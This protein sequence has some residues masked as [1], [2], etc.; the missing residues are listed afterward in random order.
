MHN[1]LAGVWLH[2]GMGIGVAAVVILCQHR[3]ENDPH[4]CE[5]GKA[6]F[7]NVAYKK[8]KRMSK[9]D[10]SISGYFHSSPASS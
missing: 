4:Y 5:K 8:G 10:D 6:T 7:L 2:S 3:P 9:G 1:Y